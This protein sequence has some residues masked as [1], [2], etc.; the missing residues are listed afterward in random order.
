MSNSTLTDIQSRVRS[1]IASVFNVNVNLLFPE[2]RLFEDL[3]VDSM[4]KLTL[5]L[6]LENEFEGAI[7]DEDASAFTSVG[8]IEQYFTKRIGSQSCLENKQS[9]DIFLYH[10]KPKPDDSLVMK[11]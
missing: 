8:A 7:S 6:K 4:D 9:P 5:L 2:N 1:V 11:V 3:G 10:I